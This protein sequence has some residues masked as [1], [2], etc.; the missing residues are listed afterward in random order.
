MNRVDRRNESIAIKCF[1]LSDGE[2]IILLIL[3]LF[4]QKYDKLQSRL[5]T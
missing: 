1:I 4:Q 5:N 2:N 3:L